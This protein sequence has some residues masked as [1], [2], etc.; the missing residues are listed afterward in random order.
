MAK[1]HFGIWMEAWCPKMASLD[2]IHDHS[3]DNSTTN[4]PPKTKPPTAHKFIWVNRKYNV[5]G[6]P[7]Q[8]APYSI[9]RKKTQE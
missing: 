6:T 2:S 3:I 9:T 8:R 1:T 5:S 7:E 4:D